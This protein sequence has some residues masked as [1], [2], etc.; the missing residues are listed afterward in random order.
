MLITLLVLDFLSVFLFAFVEP[1]LAFYLYGT[2][3]FS[4]TSFGLIVGAYGLA[5]VIGQAALGH[6]ADRYGR[7]LPIAGGLVL[8]TSFYGGLVVLTDL[9]PLL[10]ATLVAGV[11]GALVGPSL[12]A[13][14]LDITPE[15]N[16]SAVMGLKGSAAALGGV[17]GPLLVAVASAWIAPQG[18]F[19]VSAALAVVAAVVAFV[20]LRDRLA[21]HEDDPLRE[22]GGSL[23]EPQ[24][25]V[26]P[27]GVLQAAQS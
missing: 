25:G 13:A 2:L 10:V 15:A 6:A 11:G 5:M 20:V 4:T 1:Q 3:G 12:S 8:L 19:A 16:R 17:A 27:A 14:Y 24:P 23:R 26:V 18:I 9:G 7:R 21:E 22:P